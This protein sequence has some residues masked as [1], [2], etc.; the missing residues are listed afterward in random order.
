MNNILTEMM[1]VSHGGAPVWVY[2]QEKA[3]MESSYNQE[4]AV[5]NEKISKLKADNQNL[6]NENRKLREENQAL[7][8]RVKQLETER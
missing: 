8:E 3:L 5:L 2:K 4:I 7:K 6:V 1:I